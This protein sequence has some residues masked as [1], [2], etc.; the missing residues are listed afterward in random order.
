MS[1]VLGDLPAD[2]I[3][4]SSDISQVKSQSGAPV[5]ST[6]FR[7]DMT[8]DGLINSADISLVKFWSGTGIP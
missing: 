6:N 1:V 3:V 4:N 7:G 2:K 8:A 5:T